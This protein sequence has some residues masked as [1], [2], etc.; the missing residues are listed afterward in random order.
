MLTNKRILIGITG[1]IAAYKIPEL[2]RRLKD[3][4]ADVRVVMTPAAQAFITPLTLQAVSGHPVADNLL[5]PTA[6]AAMGHI[7][8]ARWAD[9]VLIAPASADFIARFCAGLGNDLLSTLCLAT[10]AP[11]VIAPA[12][13]QQ[14]WQAQATQHNIKQ[15][16][17]RNIPQWGPALGSQA[18]GEV[19]PGRMLEPAELL[20]HIND[21]LAP[22][23]LLA[24][25][26]LTIT[27]GPTREA[28]DPVRYISNHSS[29][30][31][32]FALAAEA[33]RLGADVTLISGPVNLPTPQG[34]QRVDVTSAEQMLAAS[35][36][37]AEQ[38]DIFI[39]CAAV[40]DY[41]AAEIAPEK[42]KKQG[43]RIAIELI[44]NP[45]I[46]ASVAEQTS[47][48]IVV[49][50]AAE[51]QNIAQYARNKLTQKGLHMI[52][53]ND[54]SGNDIGFNANDNALS[55]FWHDGQHTIEQSSK[56]QVAAQLLALIQQHLMQ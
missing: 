10:T 29:G 56:Q 52:A 3:N 4:G 55:V 1:G 6:E 38:Q 25:K 14:M 8:L 13:N 47:N 37:V 21:F 35:L 16:A 50:F 18:C 45:D 17:A 44:K 11:V 36:A 22:A 27:A 20:E 5:D 39:G 54:V 12:M 42:L 2:V 32:G 31:M 19:G 24:G 48:T 9:L 43:D 33:V 15:L 28:L 53:A 30:K 49:G 23:Q 26:K 34:C 51:T 41:R 40:A 46:I 7:E